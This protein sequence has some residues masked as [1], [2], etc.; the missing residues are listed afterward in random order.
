MTVLLDALQAVGV[1]SPAWL[2]LCAVLLA[3]AGAVARRQGQSARRQGARIGGLEQLART[4][5][6]RRRQLEAVLREEG[7]R[8]PYWPDDPPEFYTPTTP[9]DDDDQDDEQGTTHLET[10]YFTGHA[11]RG[12]R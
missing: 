7:I 8:L 9:A 5:R 12:K 4:E 3:I 2:V 10:Q 11:L 6:I 1:D